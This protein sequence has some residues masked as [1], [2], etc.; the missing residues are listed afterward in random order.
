MDDTKESVKKVNLDDIIDL[1][2]V[3][4]YIL[5]YLIRIAGSS[6]R[7]AVLNEIN[8][9]L[10]S[11]KVSRSSFYNSLDKLKN[12][13]FVI[14][15]DNLH[16]KG[17][18]V[19][20]TELAKEA[21][22]TANIFSIWNNIDLKKITLE[23]L[24]NIKPKLNVSE[25]HSQLIVS[26]DNFASIEIIQI[27]TQNYRSYLL[28]D[29]ETYDTYLSH[30]LA[31]IPQ[32][33]FEDDFIREPDNIFDQCIVYKYHHASYIFK[34]AIIDILKEIIRVV[35]P[36]GHIILLSFDNLPQTNNFILES[37]M[38]ELLPT[39]ILHSTNETT[40]EEDL[41]ESG[42]LPENIRIENHRGYLIAIGTVK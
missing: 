15:E 28:S 37:I 24:D 20:A 25:I 35:K 4:L 41:S 21:I 12:K 13:G 18:T 5:N 14:I 33:R 7:F 30:G 34:H 26:C 2:I 11:T 16:G 10:K 19:K 31:N 1:S 39:E 40:L 9:Q 22:Q 8:S 17:S 6:V 3:E 29:S 23:L 36:G 27:L 42:I 38:E 32:S